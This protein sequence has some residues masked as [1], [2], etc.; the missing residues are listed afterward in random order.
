MQTQNIEDAGSYERQEERRRSDQE[1]AR[2]NAETMLLH[3]IDQERANGRSGSD[4]AAAIVDTCPQALKLD[5]HPF[6]GALTRAALKAMDARDV[7][8]RAPTTSRAK[9]PPVPSMPRRVSVPDATRA[10][11]A[12]AESATTQVRGAAKAFFSYFVKE[13]D[14]EIAD[15]TREKLVAWGKRSRDHAHIASALAAQLPKAESRVADHFTSKAV[16]AIV[17]EAQAKN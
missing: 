17:K 12:A 14:C 6:F 7:E 5:G 16:A 2:R 1:K 8:L 3:L 4:L 15:M 11:Q 9:A 10:T 13:F